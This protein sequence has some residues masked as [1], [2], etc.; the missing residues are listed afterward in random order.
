MAIY[1]MIAASKAAAE[2]CCECCD[3]ANELFVAAADI[4]DSTK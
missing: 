4:F 1:W 3:A 2:P